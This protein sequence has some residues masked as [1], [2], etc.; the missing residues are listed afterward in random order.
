MI[1][2]ESSRSKNTLRMISLLLALLIWVNFSGRHEE[3]KLTQVFAPIALLYRNIPA[4]HRVQDSNYLMQV[5]VSG[6]AKELKT[7]EAG[8]INVSLDL[9]DFTSNTYTLPVTPKDV[10]ILGQYETLTVDSVRPEMVKLTLKEFG[11]KTIKLIVDYDGEPAKNFS[12]I[13]WETSPTFVTY[14]GPINEIAG[15]SHLSSQTIDISGATGSVEGQFQFDFERYIPKDTVIKDTD[16]AKIR[17]K[18]TIEENTKTKSFTDP[19]PITWES[20]RFQLSQ[21]DVRLTIEGPIS[22]VDWFDP[23]WIVPPP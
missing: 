15:F 17:Y 14:E 5:W 11:T 21:S 2:S 4:N 20:D 19:F 22:A 12:V 10:Q 1:H 18:I 6:T 23:T 3:Q 7:L 16:P 8:A 9:E 13:D